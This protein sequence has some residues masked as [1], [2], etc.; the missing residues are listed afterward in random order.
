ML[1]ILIVDDE[2]VFLNSLQREVLKLCKDNNIAV[3]ITLEDDPFTVIDDEKF[4]HNDIMLLDID[5]PDVT[6][7]QVANKINEKKGNSEKPYI[8]FVTNKDELVFDALREQ[9]LSFVRKTHLED[10][11][12]C[13]VKIH[14]KLF[15]PNI[16]SIKTGR[17]IYNISVDD[18]IYLEKKN[19]YVL[20]HTRTGILKERTNIDSKFS[21]LASY[22]F[23]RPQIGYLVN[24]RYI[25][26][27][28]KTTVL[29]STGKDIPLSKKYIKTIKQ[30]FYEWMVNKR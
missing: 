18:I 23:L 20:F 15:E 9:P 5:M 22:G 17:D 7:L 28:Q 10:L 19:N 1:N 3:K 27:I 29:L 30:D 11:T 25:E 4:L 16:Y 26:D 6:G 8:I 2:Q 12:P 21:D 13:L 14:Q 24:V